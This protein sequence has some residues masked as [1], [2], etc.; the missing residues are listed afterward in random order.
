MR[1][2][3]TGATGFLG[4]HLCRGLQA[5]GHEVL[6]LG[7]DGKKGRGLELQGLRFVSV[8]LQDRQGLVQAFE[9]LDIVVHAAALSSV[10]GPYEKF[11][12]INV[13][14]TKNVVEA[15]RKNGIGK[16][17]YISSSSVYFNFRDRFEIAES[18][19]LAEPSPSC[20]TRSKVAAE[21]VIMEAEGLDWV[22]L[23]PRGIFGPGDGSIIPRVLRI[24][25]KG[26]FP[27]PRKG[28][29]WVDLTYVENLVQLVSLVVKAEPAAWRQVYNV[30]NGQPVLI[31]DFFDQVMKG[32]GVCPRKLN[33]P[34]WL[35]KR[36]GSGV[37]SLARVLGLGEP[38]L[39]RYTVGLLCHDQTLDISNA[40]ERLGYVPCCT[41]EEGV[42]RTVE[43][44]K[45][46][47]GE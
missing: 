11:Y 19:A 20:Y 22:V 2:G 44:M 25:R 5:A 34:V 13:L 7:R 12:R 3:I 27:L 26:W 14:G 10:W 8:D 1:I 41:I 38:P 30:S 4:H 43:S 40:R 15:C 9:G 21:R 6:A 24:A 46:A 47:E 35:M 37:E 28:E 16:L 39:T 18:A 33:T 31:A 29:V 36:V 23:R 17:V 32:I 42:R 45:E